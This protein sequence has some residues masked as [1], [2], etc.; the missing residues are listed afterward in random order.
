M[1]HPVPEARGAT[2]VV[3]GSSALDDRI[4]EQLASGA[5]RVRRFSFGTTR[6]G[7]PSALQDAIRADVATVVAEH[8]AIHALVVKTPQLPDLPASGITGDALDRALRESV[9]AGFCWC[10]AVAASM[11]ERRRGVIVLV[12]SVDGFHAEAGGA[13]RSMVH[14]GLLGLVRCL[15]VEWAPLGVRVVGVAHSAEGR[16]DADAARRTPIGRLPTDVEVAATVE[17]L[18]SDEASYVVG[19]TIRVDGGLV[20]YQMF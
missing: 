9:L 2:I 10:Q 20:A 1:S 14:G 5:T 19:E 7:S 13:L 12:G 15:G 3:G 16:D 18:C 4:A 11:L 6:D 8:G 17:F